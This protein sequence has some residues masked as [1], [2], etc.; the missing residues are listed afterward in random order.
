MA[1]SVILT[2]IELPPLT[3][4]E[5]VDVVSNSTSN[6]STGGIA[7]GHTVVLQ[8]LNGV[9]ET[10]PVALTENMSN[11]PLQSAVVAVKE[12]SLKRFQGSENDAATVR[13]S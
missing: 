8:V 9:V 2:V 5:V 7:E 11:V 3:A 12:I 4:S 1:H 13:Q 6:P 10:T